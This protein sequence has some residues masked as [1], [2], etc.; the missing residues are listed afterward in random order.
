MGLV[1]SQPTSSGVLSPFRHLAFAVIWTATVISNVGMWMQD[2]AGSWLMTSLNADPRIVAL[3]QVAVSFPMF[4]LGLPAGA[5]ADIFN[6][7][8]LLISM[9]T[10]GTLLTVIFALL[11]ATNHITPAILLLLIFLTSVASALIAP[12]WE[13][14]VPQLVGKKD[15]PPAVSLNSV[16]VNISRAIGPAL[17]GWLIANWGIAI[18]FWANAISNLGVLA[19]LIWWRMPTRPKK[20][21]P[22]ERF[23]NAIRLGIRHARYNPFLRATLMRSLSFFIFASAYWALL[24]LVARNQIAGGVAIYGVLLGAIG[25]GAVIGA[26]ATAKTRKK[27]GPNRVVVLGSVG[28]AVA[29]VLFGTAREPIMAIAASLVAGVSWISVISTLNTSAQLALPEWV[30]GRGIAVYTTVMF[31]AMALGSELWGQVASIVNLAFAHYFAAVGMLAAIPLSYFWK[32]QSGQFVDLT[33]SMF[34]PE[35]MISAKVSKDRGPV[36]V[37]IEYVIDEKNQEEF[38]R[39]MYK[40]AAERRRTGAYQWGVFENIARKGHWL[41]MFVVDSWLE[42]LRQ[43]RRLTEADRLIEANVHKFQIQGEVKATHYVAPDDQD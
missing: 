4:L 6:R 24:P 17:G 20:D 28:T 5:L 41:E 21:L 30:R 9:E 8:Y 1:K 16:G 7:R 37:T 14:I 36:L 15:L 19:S 32:L 3:V 18:P 11:I 40:L 22:P 39:A 34:W 2:T 12:A 38:L 43:H 29:L 23:G 33:P 26:F 13:A 31:G 10:V 27:L 25:F 35:P 42:H